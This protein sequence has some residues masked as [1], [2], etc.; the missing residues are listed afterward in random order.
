MTSAVVCAVLTLGPAVAR[1]V[2]EEPIGASPQHPTVEQA[3]PAPAAEPRA[4]P[5]PVVTNPAAV[6]N[7]S[8]SRLLQPHATFPYTL[9]PGDNL[10]SIAA[11]FGVSVADLSRV[12]HVTGETELVAGE[13]L[14]IPNPGLARERELT[15]Q[16]NQL[17]L[18]QQAAENRAQKSE[19]ELGLRRTEVEDLTTQV[20][21]AG[22][23]LR[24]LSWWRGSAYVLGVL[25]ALMFGAMALAL[26]EWWML[27]NRFRAVA[28]M[29]ESLRR[30][31]Y[32]YKAALAKAELRLQELY[33]RRRRGIH[34]GQER[35]KLAEEAEIERLNLE[36]KTVLERHLA[37]LG[38]AG[39]SARRARWEERV[40]GIG[41]PVEAR[42]VRR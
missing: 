10:G 3:S 32:K 21:Q 42:P 36:L 12:N 8:P 26:L 22:H 37:R 2:S 31:D 28:E 34:D 9:R 16:V 13:S 7:P 25:A 30:L 27:R 18:D 5:A 38:P 11:E 20:R 33:G 39:A 41:S 24:G 23:D 29:N 4:L 19:A 6:A 1:A 15:A 40:S 35:P 14:R 17:A